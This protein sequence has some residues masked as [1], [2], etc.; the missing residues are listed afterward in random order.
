[1]GRRYRCA[2][3]AAPG[4]NCYRESRR[5]V[6]MAGF[7][8]RDVHI[9]DL[10]DKRDSVLNYDFLFMQGGFSYG[11]HVRAGGIEGALIRE[12]LSGDFRKFYRDGKIMLAVC[13]GFQAAVQAGLL[14]TGGLFEE[15]DITL[16]YNDCGNFRNLPVHLRNISK[17]RCIFTRDLDPGRVLRMPMRN[18]QGKLIT[19]GFYKGDK[20]ALNRLINNDQAVFA[21]VDP[22]GNHLD[23]QG[24]Y[25]RG[26]DPTG[27]VCHIAGIC[28]RD[29]GTILGLMPHPECR[30]DPFTDEL[31]T[32]ESGPKERG[33]G[34]I[35]FENAMK[36]LKDNL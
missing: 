15:R 2:I 1:M 9:Y 17:G 6:E 18:G 33:D 7:L 30:T 28:D 10:L 25:R 11:D 24:D 20:G 34:V 32:A 29:K 8:H 26:W 12:R 19:K 4:A 13:N 36:Y 31:W 27:S 35:I 14:T 5:A 3:L 21:Y 22:E 23:P 16:Y